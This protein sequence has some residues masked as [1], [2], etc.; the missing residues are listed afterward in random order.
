MILPS[1]DDF[2]F[3]GYAGRASRC[4]PYVQP[5]D[6]QGFILGQ[7]GRLSVWPFRTSNVRGL[8]E[9][10]SKVSQVVVYGLFSCPGVR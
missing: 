7:L 8:S 1:V 2:L 4:G 10:G 5:F 6:E 9:P 3:D